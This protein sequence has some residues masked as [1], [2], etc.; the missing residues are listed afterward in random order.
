MLRPGATPMLVDKRLIGAENDGEAA[1]R[2]YRAQVDMKLMQ[3]LLIS[4]PNPFEVSPTATEL[5][6][7]LDKATSRSSGNSV[8]WEDSHGQLLGFAIVSIYRN[9]HF[10]FGPGALTAKIGQEMMA[11]AADYA[12]LRFGKE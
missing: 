3:D 4:A 2:P 6:E 10:H 12:R 8:L 9:L 1:V 5:P 7:I 11:W